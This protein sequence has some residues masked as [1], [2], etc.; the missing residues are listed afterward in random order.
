MASIGP[1]LP[2]ELTSKRKRI[3]E[4]DPDANSP[5]AKRSRSNSP[6]AIGPALPPATLFERPAY[7]SGTP[8]K[9]P[10]AQKLLIDPEADSDSDSD[11]D[12]GPA[13]PPA[14][15]GTAPA[16]STTPP[17]SPPPDE[18]L[19]REDWMLAPPVSSGN[20]VNPL[21]PPR[22]FASKSSGQ[23]R[24]SE[25]DSLW[26]ETPEQKRQRLADEV[27]GKR[28]KGTDV[29][30]ESKEDEIRKRKQQAERKEMEQKVREHNEKNQRGGSLYKDHEKR[31]GDH[32]AMQKQD[33][34]DKSGK[35]QEEDDDPSARVFDR[36]K[37]MGL[38]MKI[39]H[40]A[41][42]DMTREAKGFG[43]RFGAGGYL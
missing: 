22:K 11:S 19:K 38:G 20:R 2:P 25:L 39:G 23:S 4:A 33:K 42:A 34:D 32:R 24:T 9:D 8:F 27:L 37:D 7:S 1:T 14:D 29:D 30:A 28:A 10:K 21:K 16:L 3:E 31:R 13:P 12:F 6:R 36:E 5:P 15:G 17:A 26:T 18:A 35:D 41:R 43:G 40:K